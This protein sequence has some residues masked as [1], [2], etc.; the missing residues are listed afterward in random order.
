MPNIGAKSKKTSKKEKNICRTSKTQDALPTTEK[1]KERPACSVEIP[2]NKLSVKI[3]VLSSVLFSI[4]L[5]LS[6]Q[7]ISGIDSRELFFYDMAR[8][9]HK[10]MVPYYDFKVYG[11]SLF[12][13]IFSLFAKKLIFY[14][15]ATS[16]LFGT[17]FGTICGIIS[18]L[19]G[20]KLSIIGILPMIWIA[21]AD[22]VL[23]PIKFS[24]FLMMLSV[25]FITSAY[26]EDTEEQNIYKNVFLSGLCSSLSFFIDFSP[27]PFI[28]MIGLLLLNPSKSRIWQKTISYFGGIILVFMIMVIITMPR[29]YTFDLLNSI[30]YYTLDF[31]DFKNLE[32]AIVFSVITFVP[33][34][35]FI[36]I[37]VKKWALMLVSTTITFMSSVG[38]DFWNSIITLTLFYGVWT[39]CLLYESNKTNNRKTLILYKIGLTSSI[40]LVFIYAAYC[41]S[42]IQTIKNTV[43]NE[44]RNL[45]EISETFNYIQANKQDFKTIQNKFFFIREK[46][47]SGM[48][49]LDLTDTAKFYS[50]VFNKENGEAD[51]VQQQNIELD[52]IK[53]LIDTAK[54]VLL[55]KNIGINSTEIIQ[56]VQD[57]FV[58]QKQNDRLGPNINIFLSKSKL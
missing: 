50:I 1:R 24:F 38:M 15:I 25:L 4:I 36:S 17:M 22:P 46:E 33:A 10:N 43:G 51:I 13:M 42:P 48:T 28:T 11:S 16:I 44:Y 30:Q 35:F 37:N 27:L 39:V 5:F 40:V 7:F 56:Y 6:L 49:V 34:A 54:I 29:S 2:K 53:N 20:T 19:F 45:G 23:T 26:N 21:A 14:R 12:T 32:S 58:I 55:P 18:K 41:I 9:I 52:S 57:N 31:S 8:N 3:T 47:E